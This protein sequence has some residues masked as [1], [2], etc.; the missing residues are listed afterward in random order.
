MS[1]KDNLKEIVRKQITSTHG[2]A[3]A[4]LLISTPEF[5]NLFNEI[6]S[7][8][9]SD[10]QLRTMNAMTDALRSSN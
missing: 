2:E 4:N 9:L 3:V 7:M 10:N 8:N 1:D 5:W 6:D